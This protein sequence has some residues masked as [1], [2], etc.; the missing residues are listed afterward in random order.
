MNITKENVDNVNAVIKVLIEK[1]DYEKTVEETLK[2][3]RQ[4]AFFPGFR[5]GKTPASLVKKRFGKAVLVEEVNKMLSQNLTKYIIDEKLNLLGEPLSNRAQQKNIDWDKDDS[6]EFV[7]D[8]A[9]A[10]DI[11]IPLSED[12]KMDFYTIK[13]TDEMI[14]NQIKMITSQMGHNDKVEEVTE[15]CLVKGDFAELDDDGQEK[16]EGISPKDVLMGVDRIKDE[17]IKK[18]FTGKHID[19]EVIFD[20]VK[21]FNDRHEVGHMLNISHEEADN[22]NS[23]FKYKIVEILEFKEAELNEDLYKKLYG[24]DTDVKTEEDLRNRLKDEIAYNL[25]Q[26]SEHKFALD[27]RDILIN[28]VNPEL[29]EAFLKRWLKETNQNITDEQ[30]ENEFDDFIKNLKWQIIRDHIAK[31]NEL[32]VDEEEALEF[33]KDITY[34]QYRQ[35][36]IHDIPEE[37]LESFAK[38]ILEKPG[39]KEKIYTKLIE[40]KV[41]NTVKD[42]ITLENKEVTQEEFNELLTKSTGNE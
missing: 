19:D 29:P 3:Y 2:E 4:K 22:L 36:G 21:A 32:K 20:P 24:E 30:I 34:A 23:T 10:P 27:T 1:P 37:R 16:P 26:S 9:F 41:I 15:K 14:N 17:E 42:K 33:A 13:V 40:D 38:M 39:E 8:V 7:F 6:F 31:N 25:L 5:P 18:L 12:D 35:Y 28:K 11:D